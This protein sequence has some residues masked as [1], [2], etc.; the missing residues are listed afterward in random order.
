MNIDNDTR[1]KLF[2][3]RS[4]ISTKNAT[5]IDHVL[6]VNNIDQYRK[7]NEKKR[8]NFSLQYNNCVN[9]L[10]RRKKKIKVILMRE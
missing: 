5:V 4:S 7:E 8:T 9:S 1:V 10:E 2:F 6:L 3:P